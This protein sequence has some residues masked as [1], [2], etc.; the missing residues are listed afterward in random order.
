MLPF[1]LSLLYVKERKSVKNRFVKQ[2]FLFVSQADER[3]IT[4]AHAALWIWR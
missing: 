1:R 4:S 2:V 3:A